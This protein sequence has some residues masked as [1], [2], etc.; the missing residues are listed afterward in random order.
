MNNSDKNQ[1]ALS[2]CFDGKNTPEVAAKGYNQLAELIINKARE[3]NILIHQ[4]ENLMKKLEAL[5]VG[6]GIPPNMYVVIAELIA[7]SYIMRGKFPD[8]WQ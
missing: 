1:A 8:S 6:D 3:N 4:D 2:L 5:D 7:F